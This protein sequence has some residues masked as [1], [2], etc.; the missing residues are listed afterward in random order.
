MTN[1]NRCFLIVTVFAVVIT[2]ALVGTVTILQYSETSAG[3]DNLASRMDQVGPRLDELQALMD[4]ALPTLND[5]SARLGELESRVDEVETLA[6]GTD[7]RLT[8]IADQVVP[9]CLAK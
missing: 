8:R 2:G 5:V 9:C 1:I 4:G 3:V 6:E 7:E